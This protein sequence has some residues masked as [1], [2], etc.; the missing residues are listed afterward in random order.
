MMLPI[1]SPTA[2]GRRAASRVPSPTERQVPRSVTRLIT[3]FCQSRMRIL[4][5]P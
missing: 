2:P 5:T 1:Q 3:R 4:L